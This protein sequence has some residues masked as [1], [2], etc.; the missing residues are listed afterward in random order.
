MSPI[1]ESRRSV[2]AGPLSGRYEALHEDPRIGDTSIS[3][4]GPR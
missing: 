4:Y 1:V 3:Q 2:K